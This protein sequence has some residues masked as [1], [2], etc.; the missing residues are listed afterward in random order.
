MVSDTL[1]EQSTASLAGPGGS[2]LGGSTATMS[3]GPPNLKHDYC[4]H[5]ADQ[6]AEEAAL[7][8]ITRGEYVSTAAKVGKE[9]ITHL[10]LGGA[11]ASNL[12]L[13]AIRAKTG[14][15]M[16]TASKLLEGAAVAALVYNAY[17]AMRAAGEE[18]AA[19]MAD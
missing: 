3:A 13:H 1:L 9:T 14:I 8:G 2:L 11:A 15:P 12:T 10:A 5:L 19:C 18:Y 17:E 16:T 7:P 6:A 4:S